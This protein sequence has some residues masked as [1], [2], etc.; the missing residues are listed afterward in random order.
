MQ[1]CRIETNVLNKRSCGVDYFITLGK[2][3]YGCS[4]RNGV[5]RLRIER[6]LVL[7]DQTKKKTTLASKLG[8]ENA[9]L[10][11]DVDVDI[12]LD[13]GR[14]IEVQSSDPQFLRKLVPYIWELQRQD[15]RSRR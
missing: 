11:F 5:K 13:D 9:T 3:I 7:A 14:K 10:Q 12:Y 6:V 15:P 1:S 2:H 8:L 4:W